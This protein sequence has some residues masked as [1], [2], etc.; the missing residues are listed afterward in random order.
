MNTDIIWAI[1][2]FNP[3]A[4]VGRDNK[5]TGIDGSPMKFQSTRPRGARLKLYPEYAEK[6]RVSIHAPAWGATIVDIPKPGIGL[7]SIHAPAWGATAARK[8][9]NLD[10]A[11]FNPRARVG[12]DLP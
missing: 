5:L 12:R 9:D 2:G 3:R 6:I 8:D 11:C 7:V 10:N 4:R 1:S